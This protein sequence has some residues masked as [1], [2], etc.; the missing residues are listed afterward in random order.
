MIIVLTNTSL[1]ERSA[2]W[3]T[4]KSHVPRVTRISQ[5]LTSVANT[6]G[7]LEVLA[8][9]IQKRTQQNKINASIYCISTLTNFNPIGHRVVERQPQRCMLDV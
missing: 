9:T 7:Y 4:Y 8:N 1:K 5:T 2:P 6:Q 3:G